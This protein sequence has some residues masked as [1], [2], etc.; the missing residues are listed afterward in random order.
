VEPLLSQIDSEF[1]Q[2]TADGAYDGTLTYQTI[3]RYSRTA[4]IVIPPRSTAIPN[5]G[6]DRL[7]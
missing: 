7:G 1:D 2:F 3:P 4:N 6:T 5:S